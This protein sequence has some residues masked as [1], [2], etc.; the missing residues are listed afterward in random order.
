M[1]SIPSVTRKEG[2]L[3]LVTIMPLIAP[4][5]APSIKTNEDVS[6]PGTSL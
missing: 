3:S 5:K 2:I 1:L 4:I 6:H